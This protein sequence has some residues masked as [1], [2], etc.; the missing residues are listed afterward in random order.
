[1]RKLLFVAFLG[2]SQMLHAVE[3]MWLPYALNI[4]DM[5]AKGLKISAEDIYS[6]NKASLKDAIFIFGGGCTSE[7]VSSKGLLF[8][9]HHCGFG[10]IANLSSVENDYLKYGFV[11]KNM[12]GEL[13]APGVTATRIVYLKDVTNEVLQGVPEFAANRKDLILANIQKIEKQSVEGTGYAAEVTEL[14]YGNQFLLEVSETFKDVRLVMTPP[15]SIG[16]FGGDTDN[17]MWP[18]HTGD[19]S[20]FR[21]YADANNKP[22]EYSKDNKP[23]TAIKHL[24]V[25][26]KGVQE[27]D[28]T[29]VYGFPGSTRQYLSSHAV[30]YILET[31]NPMRIAMREASLSVIDSRMRVSDEMRIMYAAKQARIS[32]AYKKWIGESKGLERLQAIAKKENWEALYNGRVPEG[33]EYKTVISKLKALTEKYKK[34]NTANDLYS[35]LIGVGPEMIRFVRAYQNVIENEEKLKA[36]GKWDAEVSKLKA[37]K[38]L[39][40]LDMETDKQLFAKVMPV[41]IKYSEGR[42]PE[43]IKKLQVKYGED[44]KAAADEMYSKSEFT[45]QEKVDQFW[46]NIENKKKGTYSKDPYLVMVKEIY[47]E[48]FSKIRPELKDYMPENNELMR[49]FVGGMM[50]YLPDARKYWPDANFTLRVTYGKV[51]GFEPRDGVQ[52]KAFTDERGILEKYV[53][54]NEEFDLVPELI[55]LYKSGNFGEYANKSGHLP[56][57]FAGSNHTTGG[58]S[59]SPVLNAKGELVGINFDRAWES[60]MSDVM[61]DPE[62]CRNIIV[63]ARYVLWTIDKWGKATWLIEEMDLVK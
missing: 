55:S 46:K 50:K 63:D 24:K 39:S 56:I 40:T 31:Q 21:V 10:A 9:N 27:G 16:K 32:N 36:E 52:Y 22:A 61:F 51:E 26:I 5:K 58:N 38:F 37:S 33:S 54:G 3:G 1:M 60:T 12:E 41:F 25:N 29:M 14:Y 47:E 15:S 19:F 7:M 62:K 11:A 49:I 43:S 57:A 18:R 35:E 6:V 17:W 34:L 8:T 23:Y 2:L 28:F 45:S 30:R 13:P 59:G 53:P 44:W 20:V 4:K 42:I 48:L